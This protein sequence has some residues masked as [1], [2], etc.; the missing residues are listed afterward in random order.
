MHRMTAL[1]IL[2]CIR[3]IGVYTAWLSISVL[4]YKSLIRTQISFGLPVKTHLHLHH[5]TAQSF[6]WKFQ[7]L[8]SYSIEIA[9]KL[10][11]PTFI[12]SCAQVSMPQIKTEILPCYQQ[13]CVFRHNHICILRT[14]KTLMACF[15]VPSGST[16]ESGERYR[17]K[18][19]VARLIP[20]GHH[21]HPWR[22]FGVD[23][24]LHI[25]VGGQLGS[26]TRRP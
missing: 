13:L 5:I 16:I 2:L 25:Q 23:W 9:L 14:P 1:A 12:R 3:S 8:R 20:V 6:H 18:A 7:C 22:V 4:N 24:S 10:G 17:R 11:L 15:W 19:F 21:R 26:I